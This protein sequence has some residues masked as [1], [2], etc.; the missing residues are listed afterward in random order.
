MVHRHLCGKV[1]FLL[2][3]DPQQ[4]AEV[5]PIVHLAIWP[6]VDQHIKDEKET[7]EGSGEVDILPLSKWPGLSITFQLA[8]SSHDRRWLMEL[9]LVDKVSTMP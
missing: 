6:V 1:R 9:R 5:G 7:K 2:E 3:R 4:V 8:P